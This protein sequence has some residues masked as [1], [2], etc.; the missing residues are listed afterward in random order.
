MEP[1]ISFAAVYLAIW[2]FI[3][4][5][6]WAFKAER[7][8]VSGLPLYLI[9]R[10]TRFNNWIGKISAAWPRAWRTIWNLGILTGVGSMAFIFY[11]LAKNLLNLFFRA[12]QA[13]SVQPIV[14]GGPAPGVAGRFCLGPGEKKPIRRAHRRTPT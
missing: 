3:T 7:Y 2:I 5:A 11:T 13:V 9:Y 8:G 14:P 6:W 10:T 1:V 12:E 4:V